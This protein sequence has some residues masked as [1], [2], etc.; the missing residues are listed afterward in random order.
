MRLVNTEKKWMAENQ[1]MVT[2]DQVIEL[3]QH[4]QRIILRHVRDEKT[5]A[6]IADEFRLL[7]KG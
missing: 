7:A 4:I 6:A 5:R 1:Q 3:V 2:I